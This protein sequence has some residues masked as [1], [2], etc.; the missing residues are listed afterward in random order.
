VPIWKYTIN[1]PA[2]LGVGEYVA[3]TA[4]SCSRL[5]SAAAWLVR[6]CD[7]TEPPESCVVSSEK[8]SSAPRAHLAAATGAIETVPPGSVLLIYTRDQY[9]VD[10][11]NGGIAEWYENGW[12]NTEGNAVKNI[13]ILDRIRTVIAERKLTVTLVYVPRDGSSNSKELDRQR[14]LASNMRRSKE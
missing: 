14:A 2:F 8:E 5:F 6:K 4:G 10:A 3:W 13:D 11:I 1:P 7:D 9:C 12:S